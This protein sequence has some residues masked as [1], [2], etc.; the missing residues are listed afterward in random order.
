MHTIEVSSGALACRSG[1]GRFP[2]RAV[3]AMDKQL[4]RCRFAMSKSKTF[5]ETI[6]PSAD[7]L[8]MEGLRRAA[9]AVRITL[10]MRSK[11]GIME[12]PQ[13]QCFKVQVLWRRTSFFD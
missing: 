2:G 12:E 5:V 1:G 3:E 8:S 6:E 13:L 7:G 9:L 10:G 4:E 11:K